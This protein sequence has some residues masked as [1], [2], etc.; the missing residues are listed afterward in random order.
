MSTPLY[1]PGRPSEY[2]PFGSDNRN[3]PPKAKG[4]YRIIN[5]E[6]RNVEYIGVSNDLNRRMHEHMR[7]GK[8][9]ES[10]GIFAFKT[11]DQRASQARIND[12]EREKIRQH[13]PEK[14][15]RAGGAGRP[16]KKK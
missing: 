2:R 1:K 8:L 15:L 10:N 16:Y 11:S 14:N 9:N 7:S 12:H 5:S 13:S 6:N 3:T 4:E